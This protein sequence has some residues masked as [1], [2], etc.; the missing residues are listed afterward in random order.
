ME[1]KI[2]RA[3]YEEIN[4]KLATNPEIGFSAGGGWTRTLQA[5]EDSG[6]QETETGAADEESDDFVVK[7]MFEVVVE[8]GQNSDSVDL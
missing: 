1:V 7:P 8:P 2:P 4:K 6:E 3:K 5:V